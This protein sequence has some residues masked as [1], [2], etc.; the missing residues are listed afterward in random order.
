MFLCI[1]LCIILMQKAGWHI[2]LF[3]SFSVFFNALR[4]SL[5]FL[6]H[7]NLLNSF[8]FLIIN[9]CL[10]CLIPRS[11]HLPKNQTSMQNGCRVQ[12]CVEHHMQIITVS[13]EHLLS[14]GHWRAAS[15]VTVAP[16]CSSLGF[17]FFNLTTKVFFFPP[18]PKKIKS[19]L[20]S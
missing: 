15:A 5:N 2:P 16:L 19:C 12:A 17:F 6:K 8:F 1:T 14:V 20:R 7:L 10:M 3:R 4:I 18:F 13:L 11:H 9:N